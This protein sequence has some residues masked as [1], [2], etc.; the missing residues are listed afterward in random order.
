[1]TG[2]DRKTNSRCPS[3]GGSHIYLRSPLLRI[4]LTRNEWC[5]HRATAQYRVVPALPAPFACAALTTTGGIEGQDFILNERPGPACVKSKAQ[6]ADVSQKLT[7]H[8]SKS[9]LYS[10][11]GFQPI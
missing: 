8:Q 6:S 7:F 4:K 10:A 11:F 2:K 1:M 3:S 9:A 5:A